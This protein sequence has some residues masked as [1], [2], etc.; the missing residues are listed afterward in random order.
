M[1]KY[2]LLLY[3][4]TIFQQAISELPCASV[5]KRVFMK[6]FSYENKL[7]LRENEPLGG[8]HSLIVSH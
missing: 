1:K 3:F 4:Y 6:K 2:F 5:S 8:T 7:D